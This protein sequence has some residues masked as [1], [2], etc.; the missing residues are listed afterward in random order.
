MD[1]KEVLKYLKFWSV[2]QAIGSLSKDPST[3]VGAVAFDDKMN[4]VSVGYNG[5]PRGVHDYEQRYRDREVK[6]KFISHAEANL[7]AQAAYGGRSLAGSTVMLT[8]LFPCSNCAKLFIQAGVIRVI[9]PPP[10]IN[11]R[12]GAEAEAARFMFQEAGIEQ[13]HVKKNEQEDWIINNGG[14]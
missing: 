2:A 8:S 9:S 13:I 12:W 1:K 10:D 7:V 3:K 4:I 11:D 5:F 14:L 6:Y